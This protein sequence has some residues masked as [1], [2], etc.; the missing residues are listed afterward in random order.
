MEVNQVE[1]P[2]IEEN[3]RR[4]KVV[5]KCWATYVYIL[6]YCYLILKIS[7]P[8]HP[9]QTLLCRTIQLLLFMTQNKPAYHSVNFPTG[10]MVA[11]DDNLEKIKILLFKTFIITSFFKTFLSLQFVPSY[12]SINLCNWANL[13]VWGFTDVLFFFHYVHYP[14]GH[15]AQTPTGS[16]RGI[17]FWFFQWCSCA[18]TKYPLVHSPTIQK[19]TI[20]LTWMLPESISEI[21]CVG[22]ICGGSNSVFTLYSQRRQSTHMILYEDTNI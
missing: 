7:T 4:A 1:F 10:H 8:S 11:K 19:S 13:F 15:T 16:L 5:S 3:K 20:E 14:W 22:Q 9:H 12:L 18:W 2:H 17:V 6:V 21:V